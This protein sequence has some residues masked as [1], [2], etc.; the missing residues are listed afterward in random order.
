MALKQ[1]PFQISKIWDILSEK[2]EFHGNA[3]TDFIKH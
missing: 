2:N 1:V 3:L